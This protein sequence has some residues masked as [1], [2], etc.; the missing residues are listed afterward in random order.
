ME[1]AYR[2]GVEITIQSDASVLDEHVRELLMRLCRLTFSIASASL[3][4]DWSTRSSATLPDGSGS[5]A[6]CREEAKDELVGNTTN[7]SL[8]GRYSKAVAKNMVMLIL[9]LTLTR[10][11]TLTN[12]GGTSSAYPHTHIRD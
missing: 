5:A 2:W 7:A 12:K 3:K 6:A 4:K 8:M 9:T 10:I 1:N 11:F